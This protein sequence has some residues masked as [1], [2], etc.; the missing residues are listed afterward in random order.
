MYKKSVDKQTIEYT[1]TVVP[2]S[3]RSPY[4]KYFGFPSNNANKILT[5]QK[6]ICTICGT[7]ITYNKNTS[8]LRTHLIARHP[9]KLHEIHHS[10]RKKSTDLSVSSN[11]GCNG[12]S[13]GALAD[14]V[15]EK[16]DEAF[17]SLKRFPIK[18]SISAQITRLNA[19][20]RESHE[21]EL[22]NPQ[23]QG[24][25]D[26][27]VVGNCRLECDYE[28]QNTLP[29]TE[30]LQTRKIR[31]Y[32]GGSM[33][34]NIAQKAS[35]YELLSS[36]TINDLPNAQDANP[37][38]DKNFNVGNIENEVDELSE[39]DSVAP[40]S[41]ITQKSMFDYCSDSSSCAIGVVD[42]SNYEI[43]QETSNKELLANM[44]IN[45]L[46]PINLLHGLGFRQLLSSTGFANVNNDAVER[47][48]LTEYKQMKYTLNK[49]IDINLLR[50]N[51]PYSFS[52]E[53]FINY[54]DKNI[55]SIYVNFVSNTECKLES[56]LLEEIVCTKNLDLQHTL[57]AFN[58]NLCAAIVTN[59]EN[60]SL[61]QDF[62]L[63]NSITVIS[64]LDAMLTRCLSIIFNQDTLLEI[65]NMIY[66]LSEQLNLTEVQTQCPWSKLKCLQEFMDSPLAC[67]LQCY[68]EIIFQLEP[69]MS[70]INP[71]KIAFDTINS[72]QIPLCTIVRP[73]IM[74]LFDEHFLIFN[75]DGNALTQAAQKVIN[76]E[77]HDSI[78]KCSYYSEAVFFDARFQHDFI[79]A[80]IH[81]MPEQK[82]GGS[83]GSIVRSEIKAAIC[84]R[85]QHRILEPS[86]KKDLNKMSKQYQNQACAHS[87]NV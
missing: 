54:E 8:N 51:K 31:N 4:W 84:H 53:N 72:E 55:L 86:F 25:V 38:C 71:L 40:E 36:D 85:F 60:N 48:I 33:Q 61:I 50:P 47:K 80:D 16:D 21:I 27:D 87:S 45:D 7:A 70:Y 63:A 76:T 44:L 58:L 10:Q 22:F 41:E 15:N 23:H 59:D 68:N 9:Q 37:N 34:K 74:K 77:L 18:H 13:D 75:T 39:N 12:E 17:K 62:A 19:I 14:D 26:S 78:A 6:I 1:H 32:G 20:P 83:F 46:L 28:Q 24:R 30:H 5:R 52:I 57:Q 82:L 2:A 11:S 43:Y 79:L 49:Y 42:K 73:L 29:K 65:F 3:M 67:D 66:K 64:C 69:F 56:I 35:T 81:T